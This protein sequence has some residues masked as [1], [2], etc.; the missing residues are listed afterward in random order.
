MVSI[1][2]MILER[3][4]ETTT[5]VVDWGPTINGVALGLVGG[6]LVLVIWRLIVRYRLGQLG[7]DDLCIVI[8]LVSHRFRDLEVSHS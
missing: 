3:A 1:P 7:W 6:A 5:E 4:A 8:G 2:K